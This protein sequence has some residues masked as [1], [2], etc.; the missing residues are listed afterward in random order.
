MILSEPGTREIGAR[1]WV[2]VK[3]ADPVAALIAD[4]H[5]S[6][7]TPGSPQFMPPGQ[8]LVLLGRDFSAVFGWWR[9]H[10][11]SGVRAMNGMDGWTCT[12]FR[13]VDGPLASDLVL[14]AEGALRSQVGDCGPD[15]LLTYVWPAKVRSRNPGFCFRVAGWR[16]E[17]QSADGRKILLRKPWADA[18]CAPSPR[19]AIL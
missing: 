11:R 14:D 12:I 7:R 8:T 1:H 13:R 19:G 9:P 17:G 16:H 15:G 10:P 4:G 3:K 6:R 5:Y 18:G 2:R